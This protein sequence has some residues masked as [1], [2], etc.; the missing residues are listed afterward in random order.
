MTIYILY[1]IYVHYSH[2][3]TLH[4]VHMSY[5][6]LHI[7]HH[8][9]PLSHYTPSHFSLIISYTYRHYHTSPLSSHITHHNASHPTSQFTHHHIDTMTTSHSPADYGRNISSESSYYIYFITCLL[10]CFNLSNIIYILLVLT[11]TTAAQNEVAL[12]YD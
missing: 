2:A 12:S 4:L 1:S 3:L 7:A 6:Q 5:P 10:S 9:I 8:V 11:K